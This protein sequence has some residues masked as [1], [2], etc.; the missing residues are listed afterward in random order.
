MKLF[1]SDNHYTTAPTVNSIHPKNYKNQKLGNKKES[2]TEDSTVQGLKDRKK[3]KRCSKEEI[4]TQCESNINTVA[5]E[6]VSSENIA[7]KVCVAIDKFRQ[8]YC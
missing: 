4:G 5:E 8:Y 6:I 1:S 2:D 3:K 7:R